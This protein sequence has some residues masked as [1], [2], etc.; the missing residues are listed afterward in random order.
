M[1]SRSPARDQ[2][3]LHEAALLQAEALF[4][5][6]QPLA[7]TL[8]FTRARSLDA[9]GRDTQAQD[10]YVELL[11]LD[12]RHFDGL[13]G[14]ALL[15]FRRGQRGAARKLLTRALAIRPDS[16]V[17][18]AQLGTLLAD[19]DEAAALP[20]YRRALELDP[21]NGQ[22]HRG[23]A[24]LLLRT[25]KAAEARHHG[26]LGFSG[27]LEAW[28][29]RGSGQPL[30]VLLVQSAL[31]GNVPV[32]PLLDDRI[33]HRWS[34]AAEFF[35]PSIE[36]PPHDLVFNAVGDADR[37]GGSLDAVAAALA[38]TKAPAINPPDRVRPTG[39]SDN[40]SRLARV[41]GVVAPMISEWRRAELEA[42]DAAEALASRGY[43][44]PLLLRSPGYHT[45]ENFLK[46]DDPAGLREA[47]ASLPGDTLLVLQFE[48][49]RGPDGLFRK[50]RA[51]MVDGQ[52]YP[53]HLA[54]SPHWKVHYFSADMAERA[55]HRAEDEAFLRDMPGVLGP[56]VMQAL[57]DVTALLGLD[58][59]G[60]D[61]AVDAQGQVVVFEANATMILVRPAPDPRWAYRVA[62]VDRVQ[63]AVV[64][65]LRTRAGRPARD[66]SA[67][68]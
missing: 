7:I 43:H 46:V 44:W 52:L 41:P 60:I 27:Q 42:P 39:R 65:M 22:A 16:A 20:H 49:T 36:L 56:R 5:K 14:L 6:L 4:A 8:L 28:P 29:F 62:P 37:C 13:T 48:D 58:Y 19:E 34:L 12:G 2:R 10:A 50:Y 47:T 68:G 9:L 38:K 24:V 26:R 31:G 57:Q 21:D 1:P 25:G 61:F 67:S 51:M 11:R 3:Q 15:L 66:E 59:G 45:G 35:D 18:H 63:D 17:T 40:A 53:L 64:R 30:S 32:E 55:D 33:F 23:L 54:I